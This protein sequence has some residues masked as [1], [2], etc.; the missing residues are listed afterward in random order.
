MA[1]AQ[2]TP[3]STSIASVGQFFWHAPHSMQSDGLASVATS[4]PSSNTPCGHTIEHKP[5]LMQRLGS[6]CN[7]LVAYAL[8]NLIPSILT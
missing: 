5:Q 7:V 4:S 1:E 2:P 6:Y 8:S 3:L